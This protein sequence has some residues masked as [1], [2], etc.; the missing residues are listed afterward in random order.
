MKYYIDQTTS[1]IIRKYPHRAT[2]IAQSFDEKQ[3][4]CKTW[5]YETLKSLEISAPKNIYIAGSWFGNIMTP[6]LVDLYPESVIILHDVDYEAIKISRKHYFK[7][8]DM[9]KP[10][11]I[12]STEFVYDQ[13]LVNTSCEHMPTLN[14]KKDTIVAL[15]SNNY[16]QVNEHINCV[17]SA[18]QLAEQYKIDD[19]YYTGEIEFEKYIRFMVIGK[20]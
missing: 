3:I 15:Q 16:R 2:D 20:T 17:D 7:D 8:D 11:V 14:I 10:Y 12:D 9:V 19:I 4:K 13:M 6:F 18:D 1:K 5:L